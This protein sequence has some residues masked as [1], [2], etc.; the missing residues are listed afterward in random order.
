L[1]GKQTILIIDSYVP[2]YDRESGSCRLFGIIKILIDLGY[3]VI[4]LPDNGFP[5]E[6]Y[7][8]ELQEMGV[9]V[10]YSTPQQPDLKKQLL[11]RLSFIDKAWICRPELSEKYWDII[12]HNSKIP[13]IYDTIDLHFLRL[14]RQQQFLPAKSP[15]QSWE[16]FQQR[17]T[18]L[19]KEANATVVV[20]E[21]EKDTLKNL[22]IKNV[23]VIPNIHHP[24]P[25]AIK[26]FEQR[27]DLLFIGSYNHPPNID[28]VIWLCQKIMPLI[29]QSHPEIKVTL[30]GS[31]PPEE[32]KSL[33]SDRV[34]VTGYVSDVEPYF[35]NSRVFVAPLRFGAGMKGKI[36]HSMSYGLP[37]VTTFIGAEGM[38]LIDGYDIRIAD[39]PEIFAQR[40]LELYSQPKLW[41]HLSQNSLMTIQQYSPES[42]KESLSDL[43]ES[44]ACRK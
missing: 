44:T 13:V 29:W 15:D 11:K 21:V 30:L 6:P 24:F 18:T 41:N 5:E 33:E 25:G 35:L 12:R 20:T 3:F 23:W 42:I 40:V 10:L 2:L 28:A 17:E 9:E 34:V 8:S 22:G 32:V 26:E 31:N 14:K 4:F 43:L 37:T 39:E 27:S 36:G 7:T 1:Q 16:K 38:G 19:A